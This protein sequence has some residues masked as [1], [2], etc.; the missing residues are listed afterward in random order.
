MRVLPSLAMTLLLTGLSAASARSACIPGK[1]DFTL[2]STG[3]LIAWQG[4]TLSIAHLPAAAIRKGAGIAG[5]PLGELISRRSSLSI[6]ELVTFSLEDT[7]SLVRAGKMALA[8]NIPKFARALSINFGGL[9]I[10][11]LSYCA[12]QQVNLHCGNITYYASENAVGMKCSL[13]I[14]DPADIVTP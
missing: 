7:P 1:K 3:G 5:R 14:F 8:S 2:T 6:G 4:I 12:N 13:V 9:D 11:D 10:A